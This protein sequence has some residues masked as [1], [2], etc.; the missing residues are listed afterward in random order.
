MNR[1]HHHGAR[2]PRLDP[3]ARTDGDAAKRDFCNDSSSAAPPEDTTG[4]P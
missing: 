1:Y 3:W 4:P 2:F